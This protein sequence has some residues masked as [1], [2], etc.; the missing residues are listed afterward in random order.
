MCKLTSFVVVMFMTIAAMPTKAKDSN[1]LP[2]YQSQFYWDCMKSQ[3]CLA[4]LFAGSFGTYMQCALSCFEQAESTQQQSWC[5]DL[6]GPDFFA[7]NSTKSNYYPVGRADVCYTF[8]DGKTY[9]LEGVCDKNN[10]YFHFQVACLQYGAS[11][12]CIDG[13]CINLN[14]P[15]EI[16]PIDDMDI[17]PN[18]L[19]A[20]SLTATDQDGQQ[21]S[22]MVDDLPINAE[23]TADGQFS[24]IPTCNDLGHHDITFTVSD[25]LEQ[26]FL[27]L[28]IYVADLCNTWYKSPGG[29]GE[30][31]I[32]DM[33]VT[34]D[35]HLM[36]TGLTSSPTY[37][38]KAWD[39]WLA[40][41]DMTGNVL[42][43]KVFGGTGYD[44]AKAIVQAKNGDFIVCGLNTYL[45]LKADWWILRVDSDG[46]L[47]WEFNDGEIGGEGDA[48]YDI[49]ELADGSIAATGVNG[50]SPDGGGGLDLWVMKLNGNG[51]KLWE[52]IIGGKY[53]D[54]GQA[55][56]SD[57][58]GNI[59][60]AGDTAPA[61]NG[62]GDAWLVKL[63]QQGDV[64]WQKTYATAGN[65][66]AFD[67]I[68]TTD[69]NYLLGGLREVGAANDVLLIKTDKNGNE[70]WAK[71]YGSQKKELGF[72]LAEYWDGG[73]IV[74]GK[75]NAFSNDHDPYVIKVDSAGTLEW[76]RFWTS[77]GADSIETVIVLPTGEIVLGGN[78]GPQ[79]LL[80]K[81]DE[82]GYAP[83]SP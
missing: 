10:G 5:E 38:A 1:D 66:M 30:D 33:I 57:A 80:I 74:A 2:W 35:G 19:T 11:Y 24:W 21:V 81:T 64:L 60:V 52:K 69:E 13:A 34:A 46:S 45:A 65:D 8:E 25:G 16:D 4:N 72:G 20:F 42:W 31:I 56:I 40:K 59:L 55:L 3:G 23:F 78:R 62:K 50:L 39:M 15:P 58:D 48:C 76:E 51:N 7:K 70:L 18:K 73:Y 9:L 26:S 37:G 17:F 41:A 77:V 79:A 63:T 49:I 14:H 29:N 47:L 54:E 71:N 22:W 75:S 43:N 6:D 28:D 68:A 12:E 27:T 67:L 36:L 61:D 44:T 32:Y 83:A 53:V 82:K